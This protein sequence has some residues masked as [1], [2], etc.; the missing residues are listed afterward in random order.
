VT[1]DKRPAAVFDF[2]GTLI[3]EDSAMLL[4]R[5]TLRERPRAFAQIAPLTLATGGWA[6]GLVTR[7]SVKEAI[8]R[9]LEYVPETDREAFLEKFHERI[10]LPR[11][12]PDVP[13]R[14]RWHRS[15]GH[16]LV[17]VSASVDVYLIH[18]ARSLGMDLLICSRAVLRPRVRL[19]GENCRGEEKVRRITESSFYPHTDWSN[20]W[21]Y[22]DSLSDLPLFRLCGH[23]VA[24]NPGRVLGRHARRNGWRVLGW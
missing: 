2:D 1:P 20:S 14:I 15:L 7:V 12:L 13:E 16:L 6:L 23:P 8:L 5:H 11:Y 17:L 19:V 3:R 10:L 9:V 24:V 21:A 18:A 4:L 22:G